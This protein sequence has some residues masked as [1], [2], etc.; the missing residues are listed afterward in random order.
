LGKGFGGIELEIPPVQPGIA[1]V[2]SQGL[3]APTKTLAMGLR[4]DHDSGISPP[5]SAAQR[6]AQF[7]EEGSP[8]AIKLYGMVV[9]AISYANREFGDTSPRH[10]TSCKPVVYATVACRQ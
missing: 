2:E 1:G 4:G 5:Q 10:K 6:A 7:I 9:A 3:E 8:V